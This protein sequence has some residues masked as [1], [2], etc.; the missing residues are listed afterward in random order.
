MTPETIRIIDR[1]AGCLLCA[2]LTLWRRFIDLLRPRASRGGP[3]KSVLFVKLIEQ[4]ATVLAAD[5][6]ARAAEI[7]GRNNVHFCVFEENR[8]IL[9]IVD[10]V[11]PDNIYTIR[12]GNFLQ[13]LGDALRFL[14]AIRRKGIDAAVD[15]EFFA[16]ASAILTNLTG[17]RR[18]VGLHRFTGE[19]PYRGDLMTHRVSYNPYLHTA[20]AYRQLV[21]ALA[22]DPDE[23]PMSKSVPSP[24]PDPMKFVPSA[25]EKQEI[26]D[27]LGGTPAAG[28]EGPI[29]LLN[30]NASD[31]LPLRKWPLERFAELGRELLRRYPRVR[32]FMTGAPA[33]AGSAEA[34]CREI[35]SERAKNLAGKTSMRG[36]ITLYSLADVLVTN[37]SGPAHFASLTDIDTV[38][39]YGPETPRLFGPLGGRTRIVYAK[40][41]C[42]PCVNVFNHRFSP[43]R[44]N[45]CMQ[46][47]SVEQ[48][49]NAV[50]ECLE[51]RQGR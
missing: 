15:M 40:L 25:E 45:R 50:G 34:L 1:W 26:R 27:L 18:R 29:V 39:L 48:V 46:T 7:A 6:I 22:E 13:F 20:V 10:L 28:E 49:C 5:A 38:V 11:P 35:G 9:D 23:L 41:A 16:R 51:R 4:G 17:A 19:L 24:L 31:M 30:P 2:C 12:R 36:L 42:S 43:C 8:P 37:D 47:I 33:E 3:V 44:N 32:I 14:R 21:N